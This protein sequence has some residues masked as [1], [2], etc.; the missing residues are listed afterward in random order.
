MPPGRGSGPFVPNEAAPP[1]RWIEQC[2]GAAVTPATDCATIAGPAVTVRLVTFP[3][4][5]PLPRWLSTAGLFFGAHPA[6]KSHGAR[7]SLVTP[8]TPLRYDRRAG[9]MSGLISF[10]TP[11]F[12]PAWSPDYAGLPLSRAPAARSHGAFQPEVTSAT[13]CDKARMPRSCCAVSFEG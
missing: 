9:V 11:T 7:F 4:D 12:R 1:G 5:D 13:V 10:R 2:R 6:A 3:Q 8:T